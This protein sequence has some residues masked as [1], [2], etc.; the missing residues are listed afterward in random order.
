MGRSAQD[1]DGRRGAVRQPGLATHVRQ[2]HQPHQPQG[3]RKC[4]PRGLQYST[5]F[6]ATYGD[7]ASGGDTTLV[8]AS[9]RDGD[10]EDGTLGSEVEVWG[11]A[12]MVYVPDDP[13]ERSLPGVDH[14]D[15]WHAGLSWY[16]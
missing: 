14:A 4:G 13:D 1:R 11:V 2:W 3:P 5:L 9:I 12:P 8:T 10:D 7:T 16:P 15:W 6:G